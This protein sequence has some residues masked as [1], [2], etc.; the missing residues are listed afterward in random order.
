MILAAHEWVNSRQALI[1][2]GTGFKKKGITERAELGLIDRIFGK[3]TVTELENIKF[4]S[5]K[6]TIID[7][8]V[9]A[10]RHDE[11]LKSIINNKVHDEIIEQELKKNESAGKEN[12]DLAPKRKLQET[13]YTRQV[14]PKPRSSEPNNYEPQ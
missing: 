7:Y 6:Q 14:K 5:A 2:E 4:A 1:N 9:P 11:S 8:Q 13:T 12:I 3:K 10:E